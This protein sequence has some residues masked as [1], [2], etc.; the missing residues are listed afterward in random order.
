MFRNQCLRR[1]SD[2]TF[3]KRKTY[4]KV[5]LKRKLRFEEDIPTGRR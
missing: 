1:K 3:S 5:N 4:R 2:K